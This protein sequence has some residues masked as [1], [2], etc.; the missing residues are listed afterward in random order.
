MGC[1]LFSVGW[2][3]ENPLVR[4]Q[5]G[6]Q[7]GLQV[8]TFP[9]LG[10]LPNFWGCCIFSFPLPP[11]IHLCHCGF[12]MWLQPPADCSPPPC[13][14]R[15]A[16]GHV[17]LGMG[18]RLGQPPCPMPFAQP[19]ASNAHSMVPR[20]LRRVWLAQPATRAR[21]GIAAPP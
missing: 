8:T 17:A 19:G 15:A 7:N 1:W 18:T 16:G 20:R 12:Q 3:L 2:N 13:L 5:C 14:I 21:Q 4:S 9:T 10:P 6:R 11:P